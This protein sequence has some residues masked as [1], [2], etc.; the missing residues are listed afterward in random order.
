MN[1]SKKKYTRQSE[2]SDNNDYDI[3]HLDE[4]IKKY[5]LQESRNIDNYKK[6]LYNLVNLHT[7]DVPDR[8]RN[9]I[10]NRIETLK[11][12]I[13]EIEN[14]ILMA[15]YI[16]T[17]TPIIEKYKKMIQTPVKVS[18]FNTM[19]KKEQSVNTIIS[20]NIYENEKYELMDEF[21]DIAKK[22]INIKSYKKETTQ[23]Y[24]C[25]CG[26]QYNYIE[27]NNKII[28]NECSNVHTIQSIQTSFK[29][30]D[31]VNLSQKYKYKKKVH[32][33]DTVNQYQGKQNKKIEPNTYKILEEQFEIHNLVNKEGKTYHEKY[34]NITK[35]H[36]YM[37]LFETNNSNYYEDIN[38][39]HTH[40]TG[41]PCPDITDIEHLLYED[42]DK[43]VDAYESLEDIDRIHFLNGQYILYQLLRR[44]KIKVKESDF[45]ILKTRERLVEHDEIYQK[46]CMKLEWCFLPTV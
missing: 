16:Y 42:F 6:E 12:K 21:Y 5:I 2:Q 24:V 37:F 44:R 30:I 28:C 11:Q 3:L 14:D 19:N 8:K 27:N 1:L 18:F 9:E 17:V 46:I 39:I 10:N 36:I 40:F 45:D 41:I 26:N 32:F 34:A 43:V 23:K 25:E 20:K 38:M 33:R 29:D 15:E 35:E 7:S 31:R 13:Y 4:K 22:Y